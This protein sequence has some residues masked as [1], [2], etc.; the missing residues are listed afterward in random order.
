MAAA[1]PETT[2]SVLEVLHHHLVVIPA[3]SPSPGLLSRSQL[4]AALLFEL[5]SSLAPKSP[6]YITILPRVLATLRDWRLLPEDERVSC[7]TLEN[8]A[9][10][11]AALCTPPTPGSA[12]V[13]WSH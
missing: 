3:S 5:C 9:V 8:L 10:D 4:P 6:S 1:A 12:R 2:P 11:L 13:Q 7:V